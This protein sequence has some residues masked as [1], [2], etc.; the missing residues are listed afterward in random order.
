MKISESLG[1]VAA[2]K[3]RHNKD[4]HP[5]DQIWDLVNARTQELLTE[6]WKI[7]DL[8]KVEVRP[9]DIGDAMLYGSR[10]VTS[11]IARAIGKALKTNT[12][13]IL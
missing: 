12:R 11:D 4:A 10:P 1:R 2:F 13:R 9:K 8:H 3:W 7:A 6:A 5:T